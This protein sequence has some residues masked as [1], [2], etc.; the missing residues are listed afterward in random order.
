[1]HQVRQ[2]LTA[3]GEWVDAQGLA[4]PGHAL[5]VRASA[6]GASI[7]DGPFAKTKEF[8]AGYWI[9]DVEDQARAS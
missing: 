2:E 1:M 8:L 3:A 6:Q 7:T 4:S 5:L 9:I